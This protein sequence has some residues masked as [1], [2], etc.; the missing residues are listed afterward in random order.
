MV[1]KVGQMYDMNRI[2]VGEVEKE[3]KEAG[4]TNSEKLKPCIPESL[5]KMVVSRMS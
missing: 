4:A 1:A 2:V 3:K 5:V